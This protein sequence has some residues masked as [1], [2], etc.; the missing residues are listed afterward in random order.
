MNRCA[1]VCHVAFLIV[2]PF[3]LPGLAHA[4][5]GRLLATE[6]AGPYLVSVFVSPARV[7]VGPVD[8]SVFVQASGSK[9]SSADFAVMVEAAHRETSRHV[10]QQATTEAA[11]NKLFRSAI[12]DLEVPGVWN[13][14][15]IVSDS[16][17]D[18]YTIPL[19]LT[20]MDR[21]GPDSALFYWY[22]WPVIP[23][24]LF[25]MHAFLA[26]RKQLP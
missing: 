16:E 11:T 14:F 23:V 10:R 22:S 26:H 4:D 18:R 12:C 9:K 3:G 5:G 25:A 24:V 19:E 1:V 17:G 20:V 21:S 2:F 15:I 7:T 8:L 6:R 13:L